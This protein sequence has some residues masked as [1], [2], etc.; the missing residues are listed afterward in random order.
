MMTHPMTDD[1]Y[2]AD[3][4]AA[5]L[6]VTLTKFTEQGW[7]A[8][9]VIE[10]VAVVSER[11]AAGEPLDDDQSAML[12]RGFGLLA[13]TPAEPTPELGE[14]LRTAVIAYWDEAYD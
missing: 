14:Q 10:R 8:L 5:I 12:Q 4:G 1:L 7:S 6:T 9:S 2:R 13:I 11:V 3:N